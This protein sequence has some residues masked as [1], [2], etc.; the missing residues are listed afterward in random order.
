[1]L[2]VPLGE[3]AG[4]A[5]AIV[6]GGVITGL[7]A[8]LFG[9]GGGAVIVPVLYEI[10]RVLGV[11]EEVR[12]QLC[13]G[14]S[15]AIIVPTSLRSFLAHR[16]KGN[17]PVEIIRRWAPSVIAGILAGG[18]IAAIAPSWVFKI[19]F[20]LVTSCI[21]VRMLFGNDNW[22]LGDTLPGAGLM[23]L[24]GFIIGF[25]SAVMGVGGG[26]VSTLIMVLYGTPIHSAVGVSAGIGVMISILG[27]IGFMIAGWPQ[28]ALMPPLSFGYVSLV[29]VIL[30]APIA[31]YVAPLGAKL[32]HRLPKRRL[33]IAFGLFLLAVAVRFAVSLI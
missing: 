19:A 4:L 33:E 26:S 31:A 15:L 9:V 12:M 1:M 3:L 24:Y 6:I 28:Q 32:A 22:R 27:M 5:A 30:M 13:V 10:F 8:G 16:A 29:G 14:T 7:L 21:A 25:Y 17:L 11:A 20:V 2:G 23:A 18:I